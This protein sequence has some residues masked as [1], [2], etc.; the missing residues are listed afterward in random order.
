MSSNC[1]NN[2]QGYKEIFQILIDKGVNVNAVDK[3]GHTALDVA[4]EANE[5][6][7]KFE[8]N[9]DNLNNC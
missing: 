9:Y 8:N 6:E 5:N 1:P 3:G 7:G 4:F 2:C